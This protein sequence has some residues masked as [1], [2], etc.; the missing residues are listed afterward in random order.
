M[1]WLWQFAVRDFTRPY[2]DTRQLQGPITATLL[3]SCQIPH[4]KHFW[5]EV[6]IPQLD[7]F[8]W[9][10]GGLQ[11]EG[12]RGVGVG[13]GAGGPGLEGVGGD[14]TGSHWKHFQEEVLIPKLE[15]LS[16]GRG[17]L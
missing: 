2:I 15:V 9:G 1:M 13:E 16:W 17:G 14:P 10:R 6:L 4:W 8:G 7:V 5:A 3:E 12:S 11:G